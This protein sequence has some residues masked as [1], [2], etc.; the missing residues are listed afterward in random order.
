V[1]VGGVKLAI[2]EQL[3]VFDVATMRLV[4]SEAR[5]YTRAR[6]R[7]LFIISFICKKRDAQCKPIQLKPIVAA[8]GMHRM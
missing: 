7:L 4:D 8:V 1:A 6:T 5:T 2:E 3:L